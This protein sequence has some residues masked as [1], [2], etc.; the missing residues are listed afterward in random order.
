MG[1][2]PCC[3]ADGLKKGAW[4]ADEDRKLTA[5]IQE[6]GEGGWRTLPQKAGLQRCGKSCRLRWA[7]YLRPDIKRGQFSPEEEQKIIQLHST[8]GNRWSAIARHLPMRTDNEIKNYWN[9]YIKKR[10]TK[11]GV[12]PVTHKPIDPSP[13]PSSDRDST[14]NLSPQSGN[15]D[16]NSSTRPTSSSS[17]RPPPPSSSST[18]AQLLNK[19]ASNLDLS[20]CLDNLKD[21]CHRQQQQQQQQQQQSPMMSTEMS[22]DSSVDKD[23]TTTDKG[24]PSIA[25]TTIPRPPHVPSSS[26][27]LLNKMASRLSRPLHCLNTLKSILSKSIEGRGGGGGGDGQG[28]STC[29]TTGTFGGGNFDTTTITTTD[30]GNNN[31]YYCNIHRSTSTSSLSEISTGTASDLSRSISNSSGAPYNKDVGLQEDDPFDIELLH[32]QRVLTGCIDAGMISDGG[33]SSTS[34]INVG[35]AYNSIESPM[36]PLCFMQS[37]DSPELSDLLGHCMDGS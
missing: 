16:N 34:N 3:N 10:L 35:D 22:S 6:H 29:T 4:T 17:S 33:V 28:S 12:D 18:S 9:T 13:G 7:N 32:W 21:G 1:R 2:T 14:T 23:V 5:Y 27:R 15:R 31:N 20:R 37:D 26:A 36:Y 8:L 24:S 30:H 11:M 19:L 25:T